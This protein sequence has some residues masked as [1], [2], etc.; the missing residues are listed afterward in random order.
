MCP[1][2]TSGGFAR[3]SILLH[4]ALTKLTKTCPQTMLR[5]HISC[6][7]ELQRPCSNQNNPSVV[8]R[9]GKYRILCDV[10]LLLHRAVLSLVGQ[11]EGVQHG[12]GVGLL[13]RGSRWLCQSLSLSLSLSAAFPHSP[14][15]HLP[16][17]TSRTSSKICARVSSFPPSLPPAPSHFQSSSPPLPR[18]GDVELE[19][20]AADIRSPS[21]LTRVE[22]LYL[23]IHFTTRDLADIMRAAPHLAILRLAGHVTEP[24]SELNRLPG[25]AT[26]AATAACVAGILFGSNGMATALRHVSLEDLDDDSWGIADAIALRSPHLR[27]L[28]TMCSLDP[29]TLHAMPAPAVKCLMAKE[30]G[31]KAGDYVRAVVQRYGDSLEVVCSPWQ[32]LSGGFVLEMRSRLRC[33]YDKSRTYLSGM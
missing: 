21:L 33:V 22:E 15:P 3:I 16:L 12:L 23:D 6:A 25:G 27:A 30:C 17:R 9:E 18:Q 26:A 19:T 11:A 1:Y 4:W 10:A 28:Q 5:L 32:T 24:L 2:A 29:S 13:Q 31:A 20:L 8:V 7:S 14:P